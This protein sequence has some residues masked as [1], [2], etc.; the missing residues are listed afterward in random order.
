MTGG[1]PTSGTHPL[2]DPLSLLLPKPSCAREALG[3]L[4]ST[5]FSTQDPLA[6][7]TINGSS[8]VQGRV[9]SLGVPSPSPG[10]AAVPQGK[11][12][13]GH[14]EELAGGR[15]HPKSRCAVPPGPWKRFQTAL[16]ALKERR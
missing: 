6:S 8:P 1:K 4:G 11:E 10:F 12:A 14:G 7:W 3:L 9:L 5:V 13:W 16:R 15:E 2:W